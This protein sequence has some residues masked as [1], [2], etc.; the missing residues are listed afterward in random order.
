MSETIPN[1]EPVAALSDSD[2]ILRVLAGEVTLFELIMRRYN[3][4][5]YRAAR[6]IVKSDAEA[7]DVMQEA[8]VNAF[9]HLSE[10]RGRS[11]LS[12]W[13]VRIAVHEALGRIRKGKRVTPLD[14]PDSQTFDLATPER[15][16][17]QHVSDHELGAI[18]EEAVDG[19]PE[20]FRTV[21]VLRVVEQLSVSEAAEVLGVQE[22]TVRTRLHRA[23]GL[24]QSTLVGR[25]GSALPQLFDFHLSRCDRVVH[26][27]LA[28][29]RM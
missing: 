8:Y 2:V 19:L 3:Q 22:E 7:E 14:D 23:R 10:F 28:R 25:I 15:G 12:T 6:A 11:Q 9:A 20:S 4:R 13:L 27:V 21:F 1:A 17:E 5:M 16:P 29:I 24:L 18:L 26:E